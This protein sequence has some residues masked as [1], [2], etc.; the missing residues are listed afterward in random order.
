MQPRFDAFQFS[1]DTF[2]IDCDN[3]TKGSSEMAQ[4]QRWI[5]GSAHATPGS[6]PFARRRQRRQR[7]RFSAASRGDEER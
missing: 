3:W 5:V 4:Q 6:G 1:I 7:R 2:L